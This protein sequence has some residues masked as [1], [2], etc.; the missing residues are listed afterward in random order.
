MS[1]D[2]QEFERFLAAAGD[3]ASELRAL[4]AVIRSSAPT[5][6]PVLTKGMGAPMLG[7]G[8]IPYQSKSMKQP[9]EWPVVAL[10]ARKNYVSLYISALEAGE[11]VA[12]RYAD[13]LGKVN[14]GKSCI[15]FKH[16]DDLNLEAVREILRELERRKLAGEKLYGEP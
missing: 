12:E 13:R 7:Y 3:R 11:Y 8:M 14:C 15:R 2:E 1:I 5:F 16:L 4:D 10:A 6:E 9:G